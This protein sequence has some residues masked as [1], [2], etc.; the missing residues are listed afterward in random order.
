[1]LL[2]SVQGSVYGLVLIALGRSEPGPPAAPDAEG[3]AGAEPPPPDEAEGVGEGADSAEASLEEEAAWVPPRHA[4]PFGP[5][6]V[7][8]ALEWLY[9]GDAI[10]RAFPGLSVFR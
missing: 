6:L 4:V 8:G 1:V 3:A 5:F 10:A 7:A 2:A 9:L